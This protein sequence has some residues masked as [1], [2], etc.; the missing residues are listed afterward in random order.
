MGDCRLTLTVQGEPKTLGDMAHIKGENQGSARFDAAMPEEDRNAYG[1]LIL[2]CA[3]HH[4]TI[5]QLPKQWPVAKLYE[6]K[7]AH[8]RWVVEQLDRGQIA[9]PTLEGVDF[10]TQRADYWAAKNES[11]LLAALTPLEVK[12][13]AAEFDPVTTSLTAVLQRIVVPFVDPRYPPPVCPSPNGLVYEDFRHIDES[14]AFGIEV[15]RSGHAEYALCLDDSIARSTSSVRSNGLP[16]G[17]TRDPWR[18]GGGRYLFWDLLE[19]AVHSQATVLRGIWD[20]GLPYDYAQISAILTRSSGL[21]LISGDAWRVPPRP[22]EEARFVRSHVI[23]RDAP[24]NEIEDLLLESLVRA[25]GLL[26]PPRRSDGRREPP[27]L[28]LTTRA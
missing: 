5:D 22:I 13:A 19:R 20:A 18:A 8:E 24:V 16:A 28:F 4:R 17:G 26:L 15:F 25:F 11:W 6:V 3:N 12:T 27:T 2:L 7:A 23:Q 14:V 1:N 9:E 21:S 10:V